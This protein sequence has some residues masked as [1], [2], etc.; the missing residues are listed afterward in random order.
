MNIVEHHDIFF[1]KPS[2]FRQIEAG[3][4]SLKSDRF[5]LRLHFRRIYFVL[6]Q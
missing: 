1:L 2:P 6:P 3:R 5:K 4:Y